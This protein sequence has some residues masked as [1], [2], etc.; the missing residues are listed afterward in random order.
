[1]AGP[2][3][4]PRRDW[5]IE[6]RTAPP[7]WLH[8]LGVGSPPRRLLRWC[9]ADRPALVLGSAEPDDH[10]DR[11]AAAALGLDV[12][13]RPSGGSS[14]VVG[15]GRVAW[16]DV[17]LPAGDPHW[18]GDVGVAPLWIGRA[19]AA[20]IGALGAGPLT[21][22]AGPMEHSPWSGYVCFAG[23]AP[24]EVRAAGAKVVGL[25]QRRTREAALFQCGVLLRWDPREAVAALAVDRD[26]A[27]GALQGVAVGLDTLIGRPVE[28]REVEA[29]F[30]QAVDAAAT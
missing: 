19:W 3:V 23:V 17:V 5:T 16:L 4:A 8:G 1:M 26:A 14:V 28:E 25:S 22:H 20:A 18:Q 13:R 11:P 9:H 2:P 21:V 7:A 6:R 12:V 15:P 10:V 29:A 24:G 27:A 30:E